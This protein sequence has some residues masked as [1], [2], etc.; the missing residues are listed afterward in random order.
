MQLLSTKEV[1]LRLGTSTKTV[2]RYERA[3]RL[4]AIRLTSRTIRFDASEIDRFISEAT[5]QKHP[6]R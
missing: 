5:I 4:T 2:S 3:G 6:V 1:A